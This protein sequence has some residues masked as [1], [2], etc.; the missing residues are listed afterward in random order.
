MT[1]VHTYHPSN[2]LLVIDDHVQFAHVYYI[3]IPVYIHK[4][5]DMPA[6]LIKG[7]TITGTGMQV[8]DM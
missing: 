6:C 5:L 8:S 7:D 3:Y 4:L 1:S 2:D